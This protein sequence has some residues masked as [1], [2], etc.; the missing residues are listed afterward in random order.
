MKKLL[1]QRTALLA[2]L[3]GIIDRGEATEEA[4]T[5][6]AGIEMELDRIN[7][8]IDAEE[9]NAER[10]KALQAARAE[11]EIPEKATEV[12]EF[13]SILKGES[14]DVSY[15][16]NVFAPKA[17][18]SSLIKALD[19]VLFVRRLA[20]KFMLTKAEGITVPKRTG[21]ATSFTRGDT[22]AADSTLAYGSVTI[23]PEAANAL[24]KL[25]KKLVKVSAVPIEQ[26]VISELARDIAE[27]LEA[28]YMT[29]T[30]A[31]DT[32]EGIFN[33]TAVPTSRDVTRGSGVTADAFIA[34]KNKIKSGYNPVWVIHPDNLTEVE[35]LKG[36][37]GQFIFQSSMR[38]GEPDTILGI[39]V[40]K[41]DK[42]PGTSATGDYLAA[43]V[44]FGRGYGIA[45]VEEMEMQILT[46]LYAASN[47]I[48]Y[49][50]YL[51]TSSKVLDTEAIVRIKVGA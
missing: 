28:E 37:D 26:E 21:K 7:K 3:D 46:E 6:L 38:I 9:R 23:K 34:A 51:L 11:E 25:A 17:F 4:E 49:K 44:D 41:S 22:P 24:V 31:N 1:E 18:V 5:R 40:M 27:G 39:P 32:G 8:M 2:E 47:Q 29:G 15:S 12:D 20:R 43:L 33:A 19:D 14:R 13:R 36:S 42:A 45:D 30:G 16:E 10:R 35:T 50:A 48:G